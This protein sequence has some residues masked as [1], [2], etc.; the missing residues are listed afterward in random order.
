LPDRGHTAMST[1]RRLLLFLLEMWWASRASSVPMRR[2]SALQRDVV[3]DV[4]C[5]PTFRTCLGS[6]CMSVIRGMNGH[7]S[8]QAPLDETLSSKHHRMRLARSEWRGRTLSSLADLQHLVPPGVAQGGRNKLGTNVAFDPV[9][10]LPHE[11]RRFCYVD[12]RRHRETSAR[13]RMPVN[14]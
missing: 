2:M 13:S 1:P 12:W 5:W 8:I 11:R 9:R 6:R 3:L 14:R 4:R 10:F 7:G